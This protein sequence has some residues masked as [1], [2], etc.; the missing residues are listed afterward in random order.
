MKLHIYTT[1]HCIFM[2][3]LVAAT[4]NLIGVKFEMGTLDD[5][6]RLKNKHICYVA[7]LLQDQFTFGY[8]SFRKYD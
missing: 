8:G 1:N 5:M 6:N 3:D 7:N 4:G 2:Q